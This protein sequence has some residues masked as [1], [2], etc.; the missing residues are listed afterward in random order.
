MNRSWSRTL[1]VALQQWLDYKTLQLLLH[2]VI[3]PLFSF[4]G[5]IPFHFIFYPS[6]VKKFKTGNNQIFYVGENLDICFF[7]TFAI[8]K[9]SM[10]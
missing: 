8:A 4:L 2:L 10:H 6:K 7:D 1:I 3:S 5:K 9:F